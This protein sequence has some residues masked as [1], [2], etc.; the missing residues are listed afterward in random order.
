MKGHSCY[1][2]PPANRQR[3]LPLYTRCSCSTSPL[4]VAWITAR[5]SLPREDDFARSSK[6]VILKMLSLISSIHTKDENGCI[7]SRRTFGG[8]RYCRLLKLSVSDSLFGKS[9][10][11]GTKC[12]DSQR[13]SGSQ[14]KNRRTAILLKSDGKSAKSVRRLTGNDD[15]LGCKLLGSSEFSANRCGAD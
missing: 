5:G 11:I 8:C 12:M 14:L 1:F 15:L 3:S 10:F 6:S 13:C 4:K 9:A 7:R 2:A